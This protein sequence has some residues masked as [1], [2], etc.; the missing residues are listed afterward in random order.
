MKFLNF[1][2]M[3]ITAALLTAPVFAAENTITT[4]YDY[5]SGKYGSDTTTNVEVI[6][7]TLNRIDGAWSL[8]LTIPYIRVTGNGTVIPGTIGSTSFSSGAFGGGGASST[9]TVVNS[10]LGDITGSIGYGFSPGN[11]FFEVSTKVKLGTADASKGLG[12][13]ENDYYFQF[14]G[15]I[16]NVDVIPFFTAGY[17]ITGDS[18]STTY[19]DVPYGSVG[20]MFKQSKSQT[21]GIS[22]DYKK[23]TF[24]GSENQQQV[25]AFLSVKNS[26]GWSTT[27]SGLLG[28]TNASPDFGLSIYF[29]NTY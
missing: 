2:T 5:T 24:D 25:S 1:A 15:V 3:S 7:V 16:G 11:S 13:G 8:K 28:L 19:K 27:F 4:G 26:Q 18:S 20:L 23:S 17:V 10:G 29:T 12:S 21:V 9:S 6:P 14:D 22:Y